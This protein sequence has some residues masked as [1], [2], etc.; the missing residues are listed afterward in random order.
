MSVR[1]TTSR[2]SD[3]RGSSHSVTCIHPSS[4]RGMRRTPH[5]AAQQRIH[6][7]N[8]CVSVLRLG[9]GRRSRQIHGQTLGL[10]LRPMG[11]SKPRKRSA[12]SQ[13]RNPNPEVCARLPRLR[14]EVRHPTASAQ[15]RVS[16]GARAAHRQRATLQ[17]TR[18]RQVRRVSLPAGQGA[19]DFPKRRGRSNTPA[20]VLLQEHISGFMFRASCIRS[21]SQCTFHWM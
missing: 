21:L 16:E 1:T 17:R 8:V 15:P 2:Q 11:N 19:G 9:H 3:W 13:P 6:P 18:R 14:Y 12:M 5:R 4:D 7:R 10:W 20:G